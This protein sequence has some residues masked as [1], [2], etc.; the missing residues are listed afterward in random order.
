MAKAS[1]LGKLEVTHIG[2][3]VL[4]ATTMFN[5]FPRTKKTFLR[6]NLPFKTYK[7][8]GASGCLQSCLVH[9]ISADQSQNKGPQT[10]TSQQSRVE[11]T[12]QCPRK[13][14]DKQNSLNSFNYYNGEGQGNEDELSRDQCEEKKLKCWQRDQKEK[15]VYYLLHLTI[16]ILVTIFWQRIKAKLKVRGRLYGRLIDRKSVV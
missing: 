1:G 5:S 6:G 9:T 3:K 13:A 16:K 10:W 12:G 4:G 7:I 8:W 11:A 2:C 15:A 14:V